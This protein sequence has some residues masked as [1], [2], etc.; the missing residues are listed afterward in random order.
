M[1]YQHL[2]SQWSLNS[3]SQYGFLKETGLD[4]PPEWISENQR[5]IDKFSQLP[6][7]SPTVIEK[8]KLK[9]RTGIPHE[10]RRKWWL[11]ATGGLQLLTEVGD[12]YASALRRAAKIEPSNVSDFGGAVDV[13]SFLPQSVGEKVKQFLHVIWVQNRQ[14]TFS[15]LIPTV[16]SILLLYMEPPLAY[17]SLQ[18]MI[19][20]SLQDSWYLPLNH[21]QFLAS[22]Q[23]FRDLVE[24]KCSSVLK[25]AERIGVNIAQIGLALFPVFFLPFMPLP[26]ALTMFDSYVIEGRKVL[27]RFALSLFIQEKH[28]LMDASNPQQF[29]TVLVNAMERLSAIETLCPFLKN[30]FSLYLSRGRHIYRLE[31][32]AISKGTGYL[33]PGKFK[34]AKSFRQFVSEDD[35][36]VFELLHPAPLEGSSTHK[37]MRNL[38]LH[39]LHSATPEAIAED[40]M[41]IQRKLI[42]RTL[43][44]VHGNG[45]LLSSSYFYFLRERFPPVLQLA[46]AELVFRLST[47]GTTFQSLFEASC[48]R[49][50]YILLI[51]TN[52]TV[53]GALLS[54]PLDPE[55]SSR[56]GRYY[57]RPITFV[58]REQECF[59]VL[60][61]V[62]QMFI[63]V[64]NSI[65]S[66]GGPKPAIF[67]QNG[68]STLQSER[69]ETFNS[70]PFSINP[71]GDKILEV[72]LYKLIHSTSKIS[73]V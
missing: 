3:E 48:E 69:S 70:P 73:E 18:A 39:I 16:A 37:N 12:V 51:K 20:K 72:E 25:H 67:I 56:A 55:V 15:P 6:D 21:E 30:S 60:P 53:V 40:Q 5:R 23:A 28:S 38:S 71:D 44:S 33:S 41:E 8:V 66:I 57:G 27:V 29:I 34:D 9:A 43:P 24:S 50:P 58:F 7:F 59:H 19:N 47:H 65:I 32:E 54:D 46:S 1:F 62:N 14:I 35:G 11:I 68:F 63:S 22:V 10:M 2:L 31:G 26:T 61:P 13:L 36:A 52:K 4:F 17:L 45:S 49:C 64:T 42:E